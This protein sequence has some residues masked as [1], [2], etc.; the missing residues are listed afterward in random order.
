M[1]KTPT[2]WLKRR[3]HIRHGNAPH[4]YT[5][6]LHHPPD[7]I[8]DTPI[9]KAIQHAPLPPGGRWV[10]V[11]PNGPDEPGHPVYI[12]P[13]HDGSWVIARGAG[14]SLN[15]LRLT[16]IKSEEEYRRLAQEKRQK[17]AAA[18][19]QQ[20]REFIQ[21]HGK[22]A[23]NELRQQQ[24]AAVQEIAAKKQQQ[25][26][27]FIATVAAKQGVSVESLQIPKD[28]LEQI[29]AVDPKAAERAVARNHRDNL[30]WAKA[31][32]RQTRK[33]V[34]TEYARVTQ[35]ALGEASVADIVPGASGG[36]IGYR[37]NTASLAAQ[38]GL[39]DE[40]LERITAG[41]KE[42]TR[43]EREKPPQAE[44][45]AGPAAAREAASRPR[46]QSL[47]EAGEVIA[48]GK[49]LQ[50]VEKESSA[51]K[52]RVEKVQDAA[53]IPK[54][55][56]IVTTDLSDAEARMGVEETIGADARTHAITTLVNSLNDL[57]KHGSSME[58]H[59]S[60]GAN[61]AFN[62][63]AQL[64]GGHAVDPL[65][66]D[67]LGAQGTAHM[68]VD[69]W[70][71]DL[72]SQDFQN[73]RQA[74][75][76]HHV[77][78]Q[79]K[80]ALDADGEANRLINAAESIPEPVEH[81]HNTIEAGVAAHAERVELYNRAQQVAATAAGRLEAMAALNEAF[82]GNGEHSI[83]VNLGKTTADHALNLAY[84]I[85]LSQ[86]D[87]DEKPGE[88]DLHKDADRFVLE[89]HPE[90][91][92]HLG[93]KVSAADEARAERSAAI[94]NGDEDEDGWMPSGIASRPQSTVYT[95]PLEF[96]KLDFPLDIGPDDDL[97]GIEGKLKD[98]IAQRLQAGHDPDDVRH[99]LYSA[100]FR[101]NLNLDPESRT[102]Y[103]Q[104]L[105]QVAGLHNPP[106]RGT[107]E[108]YQRW[109]EDQTQRLY[110][111]ADDYLERQRADQRLT[112]EQASLESQRIA[113]DG[114]TSEALYT[115]VLEDPRTRVAFK[116]TGEAWS[117][118]ERAAVRSYFFEHI[119]GVDAKDDS[120]AEPLAPDEKHAWETWN[121]L[122]AT[123][124]PY[125]EIQRQWQ[126][127]QQ[128]EAGV[129][130][131]GEQQEPHPF[132]TVD[133]NDDS[134]VLKAAQENPA[135]LGYQHLVAADGKKF[136]PEVTP[137]TEYEA[138]RKV[139]KERKVV[140]ALRTE[141]TI[142]QAA[143][144]KLKDY[145]KGYAVGAIAGH[146]ELTERHFDPEDV[147]TVSDNWTEFVKSIGG[148]NRATR[149]VQEMMQGDLIRRFAPRYEA[150]T[151]KKLVAL[152]KPIEN[153]RQFVR[154][155]AS[156]ESRR[157]LKKERKRLQAELQRNE[158]GQWSEGEV[159]SK[160]AAAEI[161]KLENPS[162][163]QA[164]ERR[165]NLVN[166]LRATLGK[167]VEGTLSTLMPHIDLNKGATAATD[168]R[169]SGQYVH[170][171][172]AIK[173]IEALKRMS[174]NL[175]AGT[176]KT[177]VAIGAFTDLLSRGEAKRALFC[178]PQNLVGQFASEMYRFVDPA[179]RL[180]W[181]ADTTASAQER[182]QAYGDPGRH[183]V[184]VTP[185]AL[186]EDITQAIAQ[187]RKIPAE[188][189]PE[190]LDG[191]SPKDQDEIIHKVLHQNG[192]NFDYQLFD[193]GHRLLNR[194]G[195]PDSHMARIA[196]SLSRS[197]TH[198]L[199]STA[200]P[201]K[202]DACIHP[203]TMI[204]DPVRGLSLAVSEWAV[205]NMRPWV[206]ATEDGDGVYLVQASVPFV[207]CKSGMYRVETAAGFAV[208]VARSHRFLTPLGWRP[209]SALGVGSEIA[210]DLPASSRVALE[211]SG[212]LPGAPCNV[213]SS[214]LRDS[215]DA[216]LTSDD[217]DEHSRSSHVPP[218][219]EDDQEVFYAENPLAFAPLSRSDQSS[220]TKCA[221]RCSG[222][223]SGSP[224]SCYSGSHLY[225]EQPL[226]V[227][228]IAPAD[229]PLLG[230][231][232]VHTLP[233][234]H[235]DDQQLSPRRNRLESDTDHLSTSSVSDHPGIQD[236]DRADDWTE[237]HGP[238]RSARW[239]PGRIPMHPTSASMSSP[240]PPTHES[241]LQ[242]QSSIDPASP[243]SYTVS[244]TE[245]VDIF[246][247]G[248]DDV[249]DLTVPVFHNYLAHGIWHHNSE[250]WDV[251][252]KVDP[253]KYHAGTREAFLRKYGRNTLASGRA[254]RAEMEPY[255]YAASMDFGNPPPRRRIRQLDLTL[256][257][258]KDYD[259]VEDAYRAAR[260]AQIRGT[261]NLEAL[262]VLNPAAFS[263]GEP[264]HETIT[265]MTS[266][267]GALRQTAL[268]RVVN[269]H[270]DGV[271]L[272]WTQRYIQKHKSQPVVVF[273]H[274]LKAIE[275]LKQKL[276]A[277]GHRVAVVTGDETGAAKDK[278]YRQFQSGDVDILLSSDAG[279]A[280]A[281]LQRGFHL[282]NIDVPMTAK[283]HEQRIAR[284]WRLGQTKQVR[285]HDLVT[286]TEYDRKARKRLENKRGLREVL[287]SD[288][289]R[290]DDTGL[291]TRIAQAIGKRFERRYSDHTDERQAA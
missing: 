85:G 214:P 138:I 166:P 11:H 121:E 29:A 287:T 202:N 201:V 153:T 185:E 266:S 23:Y 151:G 136:Y 9:T 32:D 145:L 231:A 262:Q 161:Q 203:D 279:E 53:Q 245:I 33:L 204:N 94:K 225:G 135:A 19:R 49:K 209:L 210:C 64:V 110:G 155:A 59:Y 247:V 40:Q 22:E 99:D 257:Q 7:H 124:D 28:E 35:D 211:G 150:I 42:Q 157:R 232:P 177:P 241:D 126:Q 46:V 172:R 95:D 75:R 120:L 235:K 36:G 21:E 168:V 221:Q 130:L 54:A 227:P 89:V 250:A 68:L 277:A 50:Q 216:P 72:S 105:Q 206:W 253:E 115:S 160:M 274:N 178:V 132:S 47:E 56:V 220:P 71:R 243:T 61:T 268:N 240:V 238:D 66:S 114:A 90:G 4:T 186:R 60:V 108:D 181:H 65:L 222:T 119:A 129:S 102:R 288:V 148:I 51:A 144:Q 116:K 271:K 193:E 239:S 230:D 280:G 77:E 44:P 81:E 228:G 88:F 223:A 146:P 83:Q 284:E 109:R 128:A 87:E 276:T 117:P 189:V 122:S 272:Q 187:D 255:M 139:G 158:K 198:Y 97:P 48:A 281:N 275:A 224:E 159:A 263:D 196:D 162:L 82:M 98:Y 31:I 191:K 37:T 14:G 6:T 24:K 52:S 269:E 182:Q 195:K 200:D 286:N 285:V 125:A 283:T 91:L 163:T 8:W 265:N 96:D 107:I 278:A 113:S 164:E 217:P 78:T 273:A 2:G 167:A 173:L 291:A 176:G 147:E 212:A 118:E 58:E 237:C 17:Q 192:W 26:K 190:L 152:Q 103:E 251:L 143:R 16:G 55:A 3:V 92:R 12:V 256:A 194:K 62:E 188:Q 258:Q 254:L 264:D 248:E 70:R 215:F 86:I 197:A 1:S 290:M 127:K 141:A 242:T 156:P 259:S 112:E 39:T 218:A 149:A 10:T 205:R 208:T 249:Y 140:T 289:E 246:H 171:Q 267:L 180:S 123:G 41:L 244:Y 69:Q 93:E 236:D 20:K 199:Y 101:N 45:S 25:E 76:D 234:S 34:A 207:K 165:P 229:L 27:D 79:V 226:R 175:Q 261:T 104:A 5:A 260:A 131:F 137:G 111:Y 67:T 74:L 233:C 38:N 13:H 80:I 142:T 184:V 282:I 174:I 170:Q 213:S 18:S 84:A 154:A 57:A 133:L 100:T 270:P 179:A 43:G 134:A 106:T 183:V 15:G 252:H 169:M 30:K 63:V 73:L 219:Y